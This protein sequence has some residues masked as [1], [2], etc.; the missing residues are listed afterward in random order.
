MGT[1]AFNIIIICN[2]LYYRKFTRMNK[3][4]FISPK[5]IS[6]R[7]K[8]RGLQKLRWYCQICNKQCRDENGFVCHILSEGHIRMIKIFKDKP[9]FFVDGYSKLFEKMFLTQLRLCHYSYRTHANKFYKA[10]IR[11][12]HHVHMN[13][14]KWLTLSEFIKNLGYTDKCIIEESIF[15]LY[16]TNY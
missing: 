8:V 9:D 10:V 11:D 16:I 12:K 3:N 1:P 13:S 2:Y 4:I 7:F 15:G 14:T 6:N 5:E